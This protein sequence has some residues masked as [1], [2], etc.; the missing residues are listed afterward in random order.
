MDTEELGLIGAAIASLA[1]VS[2]GLIDLLKT[3]RAPEVLGV[4][5]VALLTTKIDMAL[6]EL[7]DVRTALEE[8]AKGDKENIAEFNSFL[9]EIYHRSEELIRMHRDV[10]SPFSTEETNKLLNKM[11]QQMEGMRTQLGSRGTFSEQ[12]YL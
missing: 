10:N 11:L 8:H 7:A 6:R 1:L 12:D 4:A 5:D 2:R 3:N 9:I